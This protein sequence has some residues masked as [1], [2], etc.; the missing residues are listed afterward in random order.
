M[1]LITWSVSRFYGKLLER[2]VIAIMAGNKLAVRSACF[3]TDMLH[4]RAS[5]KCPFNR[6]VG[7][8]IAY[9]VEVSLNSVFTIQKERLNY[10][11]GK[12]LFIYKDNSNNILHNGIGKTLPIYNLHSPLC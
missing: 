5:L 8:K 11:Q 9:L 7:Y 12:V 10:Y 3:P 6:G 1:K 2:K 4:Y